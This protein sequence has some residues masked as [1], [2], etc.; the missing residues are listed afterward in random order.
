MSNLL[1]KIAISAECSCRYGGA[2]RLTANYAKCTNKDVYQL[3][4]NWTF[5]KIWDRK[6]INQ[7]PNEEII[8]S[9][10]VNK[11]NLQLYKNKKHIKFLH[12]FNS[13]PFTTKSSKILEFPWITHR[14]RTYEKLMDM[15]L[16]A[17]LIDDGYILYDDNFTEYS[18]EQK[19]NQ[20]CFVSR[21]EE[22]KKPEWAALAA[23][24]AQ[25]PV[26]FAGAQRFSKDYINLKKRFPNFQIYKA[27]LDRGISEDIKVSILKKSKILLHCSKGNLRDYLE[28]AI[29]DGMLYGSIPICITPDKE[30]F[31]I[32]E[33][34]ELGFV[35]SS[36]LEASKKIKEVLKN[37]DYYYK[38]TKEF[39]GVFLKK[40]EKILKNWNA[41]I[42]R[43]IKENFL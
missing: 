18:L 38:N 2:Q 24:K 41:T 11:H 13:F 20:A 23:K 7:I 14:N 40:Q 6:V 31:K 36:P 15:G 25:I 34:L 9:I 4:K 32:I 1:N 42:E 12:S 28:Y 17:Y 8:F 19:E 21:I 16:N 22:D 39:M 30:Q 26:I 5:T 35:T 43:I 27:E 37:Y 10:V 3:D 29:L 33:E